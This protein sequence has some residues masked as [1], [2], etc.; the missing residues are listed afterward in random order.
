MESRFILYTKYICIYFALLKSPQNIWR[1]L[2]CNQ[3]E[4]LLDASSP[5]T[6]RNFNYVRVFNEHSYSMPWTYNLCYS[7]KK[8]YR[9]HREHLLRRWTLSPCTFPAFLDDINQILP[10]GEKKCWNYGTHFILLLVI[11]AMTLISFNNMFYIN[12]CISWF[13]NHEAFIFYH[14]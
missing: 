6:H 12:V 1:G 13:T 11:T 3:I 14:F 9:F 7:K 8:H 2:R 5:K 4:L 10:L